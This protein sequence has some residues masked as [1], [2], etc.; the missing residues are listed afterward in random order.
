VERDF[1]PTKDVRIAG[2]VRGALAI[3]LALVLVSIVLPNTVKANDK[4]RE[5]L[6]AVMKGDQEQATRLL[7]VGADPNA[8]DQAGW[9]GL[10]WAVTKGQ[11]ALVNYLL[12]KRTNVNAKV[13]VGNTDLI[14]AAWGGNPEVVK[15]LLEKGADVN[16]KTK[17]RE[18]ALKVA[19]GEEVRKVLMEHGAKES[20]HSLPRD[21]ASPQALQ[22][23]QDSPTPRNQ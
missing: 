10:T 17:R 18:T 4:N 1:M 2:V 19:Y 8:R 3:T 6:L 20:L 9:T 5:L 15:L 12:D 13:K 7:G 23:K 16:A 11:P 14:D 21:A 22:K